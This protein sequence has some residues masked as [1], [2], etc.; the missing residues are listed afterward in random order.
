MNPKASIR[1]LIG[2]AIGCIALIVA[3]VW[4][5][6][7]SKRSVSQQ[8]QNHLQ[9]E[10]ALSSWSQKPIPL[11][12]NPPRIDGG[13]EQGYV[14]MEAKESDGRFENHYT[15]YLLVPTSRIRDIFIYDGNNL[16]WDRNYNVCFFK[17]ST[18]PDDRYMEF[19]A[20]TNEKRWNELK[21]GDLSS[22]NCFIIPWSS[23]GEFTSYLQKFSEWNIR[24]A[25]RDIGR[26]KEPIG[27]I[28]NWVNLSFWPDTQLNSRLHIE[29]VYDEGLNAHL[30]G[31]SLLKDIF[32][33]EKEC[34][35]LLQLLEKKDELERL[36]AEAL[37]ASVE[38]TS[39]QSKTRKELLK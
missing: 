33:E 7:R 19:L 16:K 11:S 32:F 34:K 35:V 10:N 9:N 31:R 27:K 38:T 20:Q 4:M 22:L 13:V 36:A 23:V 15:L 1:Q 24:A 12:F 30:D 14:T 37:S 17:V 6:L 29:P 25:N 18:R 26:D 8:E 5:P 39:R 28:S 3:A 2:I 21:S